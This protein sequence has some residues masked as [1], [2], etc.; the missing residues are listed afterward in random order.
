MWGPCFRGQ[1]SSCSIVPFLSR[2]WDVCASRC[3][4]SLRK[5][6]APGSSTV[7]PVSSCREGG[8]LPT[9]Q[10]RCSYWHIFLIFTRTLGMERFWPI[11]WTLKEF[12]QMCLSKEHGFSEKCGCWSELN[13]QAQKWNSFWVHAQ[14]W[15]VGLQTQFQDLWF[16]V[17][18][19]VSWIWAIILQKPK[20][21]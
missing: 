15:T 16:A 2:S 4:C 7:K 12:C 11:T 18:L 6:K 14:N 3:S 9:D 20:C 21:T 5:V 13:L 19:V 1:P 8:S 10:A 17:Y